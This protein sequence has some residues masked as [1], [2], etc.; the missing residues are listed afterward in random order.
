MT[1]WISRGS[2]PQTMPTRRAI[3]K[4]KSRKRATMPRGTVKADATG[5]VVKLVNYRNGKTFS[6]PR[7]ERL[8]EVRYLWSKRF[9]S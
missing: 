1:M 2:T 8:L 7:T 6:G 5:G 3:G 9:G 4:I